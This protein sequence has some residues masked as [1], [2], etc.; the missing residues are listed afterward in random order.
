MSIL[1]RN[2]WFNHTWLPYNIHFSS[3]FTLPWLPL[4][5]KRTYVNVSYIQ[6]N[7]ALKWFIFVFVFGILFSAILQFWRRKFE[8]DPFVILPLNVQ[9]LSA[10]WILETFCH[11]KNRSKDLD[12]VSYFRFTISKVSTCLTFICCHWCKTNKNRPLH[13]WS[14]PH[15]ILIQGHA[16]GTSTSLFQVG[17]SREF[18]VFH[19]K[20]LFFLSHS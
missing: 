5:Q 9:F 8:H 4:P 2:T 1:V 19:G 17:R 12:S 16:D 13:C 15:L 14:F 6:S 7:N 3:R 20:T 18:F 10:Q 11:A